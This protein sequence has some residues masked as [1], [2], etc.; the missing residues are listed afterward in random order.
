MY[1]FRKLFVPMVVLWFLGE[2]D[3][4]NLKFVQRDTDIDQ[5]SFPP[6]NQIL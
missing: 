1:F 2:R 3:F 5:T 4:S 6:K